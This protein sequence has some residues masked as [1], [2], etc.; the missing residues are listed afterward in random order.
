MTNPLMKSDPATR[1]ELVDYEIAPHATPEPITISPRYYPAP[2][3]GPEAGSLALYWNILLRRRWSILAVVFLATLTATLA[4]LKMKPIYKATARIEV[5]ADTPQTQMLNDRYQQLQTDQDFLRTQVQ[6]LQSDNLAWRTIEQLGLADNRM[7]ADESRVIDAQAHKMKLIETFKRQLSVELVPGSRVVL[8]GFESRDPE[9]A[10]RIANTQVENYSDRNF[11]QKYD[12]TRQAAGKME[13]Q[14]DELKAK[15]EKSQRALVEYE[16]QNAI[17][18][19]GEKQNVVQQRLGEISTNF[20][21]SQNDRIQKEALYNQIQANPDQVPAIA[22]NE[23]MQKLEENYAN[24]RGQYVEALNQYGPNY[25]KVLRLDKQVKEAS[26][27]IAAER[28]RIAQRIRNEYFAAARREQLLGATLAEQK[29][30]SGNFNRLLIEHDLLKGDFEANQQLYQRLLQRVK[31]ATVIAGLS[32]TNIHIVDPA[33]APIIPVRPRTRLNIV[34]GLLVGMIFGSMLAFIQDSLD[35]S[36]KSPEEVEMLIATRALALIPMKR[37]TRA[38]RL[39]AT[40]R[41]INARENGTALLNVAAQTTSEQSEAY[42]ALRTSV[43]LSVASRAPQTVLITS[44]KIG[45]GKSSTALNLA[46][47]LAQCGSSVVLLDCDLRKPILARLLGIQNERGM[48]THLTGHDSIDDV[49]QQYGE[50]PNLWL[51]PSGPIPPNPAELLCSEAMESLFAELRQRFKHIII[52]SPP[53]LAVT[54]ATVLASAVDGVILVVESGVTPK[55][56]VS[57]ARNILDGA[58]ARLLGVALNKVH[59][60]HDGYY[61]SYYSGYHA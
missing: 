38:E 28:G 13:E 14:L 51:I 18:S 9:L 53:L 16:R 23:V 52:D 46:M 49:I 17:L 44:A 19:I 10:A 30:E 12:A 45:E 6:V 57:R 54:D 4:S 29:K 61:G 55:K 34:L 3:S 39:L 1:R 58:N 20:T 32:S 11:R 15:V 40:N 33:L 31:D 56:F 24:L 35:N 36:L 5:E 60:H 22:N 27:L 25:P 21:Q 59:M 42:R 2:N 37:L 43:L 41:S 50:Q 48:S 47:A 26:A 8:V 7:F